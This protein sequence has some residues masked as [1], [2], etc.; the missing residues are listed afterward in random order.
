MAL[1]FVQEPVASADKVPV[2]TNWN[3]VVPYTLY[4][5]T[6]SGLFYFRLVLEVRLTDAS[7]T[8]LA[9]MKQRRNGY[10]TDIS[11]NAAR[12]TFDIRDIVNTQLEDTIAD[13]NATTKSIHTLGK[14][15]TSTIFSKN[16]NQLLQIYVKGYQN[17]SSAANVS[18]TD[19]TSGA[20]D[21]TRW[22]IAASLALEVG[23]GTDNFQTDAFEDYT[24]SSALE[25]VLSDLPYIPNQQSSNNR[26]VNYVQSTDYHTI[27][28]L[29]YEDKFDSECNFFEIVYYNSANSIIG[30]KQYIR[31]HATTGGAIPSAS[32]GEADTDVERLLYFGCGPQNL[33]DSNVSAT[34]SSGSAAGQARP[35]NFSG[36]AYYSVRG[37]DTASDSGNY[38]TAPY[39]FVLQDGSCKG[40]K[41]RR[42]G[43]RNSKGCYDY[44]NFKMKS[45]QTVQV[46][47]NNYST[48]LG[49]FSNTMYSY[50]N[51]ARGK[52]TRQTT[53]MLRETLNTDWISEEETTLLESL[54]MSTNV[55]IIENADTTY[56][57]PVMI[58]DTNFVR[59][60]VA[61]EGV[62]IQY[63]INIEYANPLNTNS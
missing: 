53:A 23:R 20:V 14:N 40:F 6:I 58:T 12:A 7:G 45:T 17:Y 2:I 16:S 3:P 55:N 50:D 63:T 47:R 57:V 54:L 42:L 48:M 28:F 46:S 36:Y 34:D 60:T 5:S 10:A 4:E 49:D 35:S 26:L 39:Y 19:D 25:Y 30:N 43:W 13:Q 21:D 24:S 62:K 59:K 41:V 9:K 44:F 29:N 31:N 1:S 38:Q 18:P 61:N 33:Q 27:G 15:L 22:Y 37:S 32:G 11:G 56:T 8:L 52:R 51:F